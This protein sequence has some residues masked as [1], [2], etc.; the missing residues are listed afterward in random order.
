MAANPAV[1]VHLLCAG[2]WVFA[3][4]GEGTRAGES[5]VGEVCCKASLGGFT[6]KGTVLRSEVG[7]VAESGVNWVV[8]NS[9]KGAVKSWRTWIMKTQ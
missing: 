7:S 2:P 3:A 9:Q 5:G 4:E 1:I 8:G 6:V